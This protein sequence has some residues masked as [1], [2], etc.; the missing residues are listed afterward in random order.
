M[1]LETLRF[2]GGNQVIKIAELR[3]G[4]C[5]AAREVVMGIAITTVS[6]LAL[7]APG[8]L[9]GKAPGGE[10]VAPVPIQIQLVMP[11][12]AGIPDTTIV[13]QDALGKKR[14]PVRPQAPAGAQVAQKPKLMVK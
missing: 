9:S 11:A 5:K 3:A 2:Q 4:A 10:K 14:F 7:W 6:E 13:L 8:A 1:C 12:Q